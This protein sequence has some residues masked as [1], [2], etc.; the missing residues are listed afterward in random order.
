MWAQRV[1]L[2]Q[3]PYTIITYAAIDVA[4][5]L[6]RLKILDEMPLMILS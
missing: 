2:K 6:V 5:M 3:V 4:K 1:H